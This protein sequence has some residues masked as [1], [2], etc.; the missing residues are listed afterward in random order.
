MTQP[1]CDLY[2][3]HGAALQVLPAHFQDFGGRIRFSGPAVTVKCFEDNSRVKELA[4][5]PG[6]GRVLVVDGGGSDRCALLG[7][8]IGANFEKNGWAGVIVFGLIRDRAE[9]AR[10]D[11]GV[12]ALGSIPRPSTRRDEGRVDLA[13]QIGEATIHPGDQVFADED[14]IVVLPA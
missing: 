12:K 5:T 3:E 14:G 2:D 4:K 1:T 10:L 6:E 8:M 7:D 13:I 11:L 9:L